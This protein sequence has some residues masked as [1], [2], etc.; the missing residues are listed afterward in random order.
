MLNA[1][2]KGCI[3]G[4]VQYSFRWNIS[5][6]VLWYSIVSD[7]MSLLK[8]QIHVKLTLKK[9]SFLFVTVFVDEYCKIP[10]L[11]TTSTECFVRI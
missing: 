1:F 9:D 8:E 5:A 10:F 6:L 2:Q 3:S 7:G 11:Y 4:V